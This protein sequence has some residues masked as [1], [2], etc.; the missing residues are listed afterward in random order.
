MLLSVIASLGTKNCS[1]QV[2]IGAIFYLKMHQKLF[3]SR[4]PP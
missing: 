1:I 2:R 3:A 4:A